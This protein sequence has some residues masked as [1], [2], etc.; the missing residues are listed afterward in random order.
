M[1]TNKS[2]EIK[3]IVDT[4]YKAIIEQRLRAGTR[5]IE[6]KLTAALDANRNHVRSALQELSQ[7]NIVSIELN[8]GAFVS[9]PTKQDAMHIFES[10]RVI[11]SAQVYKAVTLAKERDIKSLQKIIAAERKAIDNGSRADMVRLSGE[12]HLAVSRIAG[13]KRLTMVLDDLIASSSI[14]VGMYERAG[15]FSSSCDAQEE[16]VKLFVRKDANSASE[17]VMEHL[18]KLEQKLISAY[19]NEEELDLMTALAG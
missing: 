18:N 17:L 3:R 14:I 13:N 16:L 1:S 11:Q 19:D 8:R 5:L 9:S 7:R 6:S 2:Q 15:D 10:R 4:I 12:F